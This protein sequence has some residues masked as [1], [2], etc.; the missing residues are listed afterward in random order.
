MKSRKLLFLLGGSSA[1]FDVVADK[2][3]AAA[4]GCDATIVLL[5]AGAPGWEDY[6]SQYTQ[7]WRQRGVTH[8]YTIVPGEKMEI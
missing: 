1:L 2:F 7:P 3:V 5:L 4:G 8:H 6:V